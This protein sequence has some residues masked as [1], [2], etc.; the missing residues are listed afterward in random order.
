PYGVLD[1]A[2]NCFEWVRDWYASD[3]WEKAPEKNPA[4][5]ATGTNKVLK[6]GDSGHSEEFSRISFRYLCPPS[7]RDYTKVTFRCVVGK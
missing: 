4:G 5:P 6:G 3:Y 2:G 1:M 7:A